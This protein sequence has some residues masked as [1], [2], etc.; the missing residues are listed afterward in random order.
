MQDTAMGIKA[1]ITALCAALTIIWGWFG[2]LVVGLIVA[3]SADYVTGWLHAR[4]T[5]NWQSSI[6]KK[7]LTKK[8][9]V[10]G[11][12]MVAGMADMVIGSMLT[13]IPGLVLPFAYTVLLCPIVVIWYLLAELGSILENCAALGAKQI[14]FLSKLINMLKTT[15]ERTGGKI[16]PGDPDSKE[17]TKNE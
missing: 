15:I 10:L 2:W 8:V 6:A 1:G 14:P 16:I 5:G 12:V 4:N 13:N 3:M 7:G 11:V 9:A 17:V